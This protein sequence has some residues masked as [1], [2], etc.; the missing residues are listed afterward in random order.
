MCNFESYNMERLLDLRHI[1]A[2][3]AVVDEG[4][5][6][7]AA[8][9]IAI[10]QSAVSHAIRRLEEQL[11]CGLL[12]RSG[13]SVILTESGELFLVRCRKILAEIG[14]VS[15]DLEHGPPG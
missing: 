11:A 1:R 5:F 10:T 2:F 15:R 8:K 14:Q 9:K 6:T 12:D 13:K 4:S 3:V 7:L